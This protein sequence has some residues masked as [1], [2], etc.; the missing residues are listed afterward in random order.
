MKRGLRNMILSLDDAKKRVFYLW[1]L[2]LLAEDVRRKD[3][4]MK[5]N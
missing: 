2:G 5:V 1:K 3:R 4:D